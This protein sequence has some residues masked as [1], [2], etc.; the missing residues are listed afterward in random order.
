MPGLELQGYWR[1]VSCPVSVKFILDWE[2]CCGR[3][4]FTESFLT[5]SRVSF[6]PEVALNG[7]D[8]ISYPYWHLS[9]PAVEACKS[10][11]NDEPSISG[12]HGQIRASRLNSLYTSLDD[13]SS[14]S[15]WLNAMIIDY[16]C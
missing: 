13:E 7:E 3:K 2:I 15:Y 14:Y 8:R 16:N 5:L 4:L 11:S 9:G 6:G 1:D 10:V 12:L